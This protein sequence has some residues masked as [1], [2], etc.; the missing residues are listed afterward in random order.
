MKMQKYAL[1][2]LFLAATHGMAADE[3]DT[4]RVSA[5]DGTL[6]EVYTVQKGTKI[7]QGRFVSYHPNGKIG[8]ESNY[9]D[10]KLDG[11]Y[12]SYYVNGQLWQEVE[13]AVGKEHGVSKTYYENGKLRNQDTFV[14]GIPEGT[15]KEWDSTGTLRSEMTYVRGYINGV[16]RM[17]DAN[18]MISEDMEF[19][20]GVREG[21]YHKYNKGIVV[22]TAKFRRNRCV[23]NCKF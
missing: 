6:Q 3:L 7:R 18:G 8:V 9:L 2:A 20:N 16:A 12:K 14:M 17:F 21:H 13:Y 15:S 4:V 5:A 22:H 10:G 19:V 11:L 23:E 1:I